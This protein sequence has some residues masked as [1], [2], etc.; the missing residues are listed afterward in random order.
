MGSAAVYYFSDMRE[1]LEGELKEIRHSHSV[2]EFLKAYQD[3]HVSKNFAAL[4]KATETR[5][6]PSVM[7]TRLFTC[8]MMKKAEVYFS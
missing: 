4:Y 1:A 2:E 6:W 3:E 5:D 7:Q 8:S